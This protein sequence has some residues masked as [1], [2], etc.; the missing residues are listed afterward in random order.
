ME[1]PPVAPTTGQPIGA[2]AMQL[3]RQRQLH[4][5]GRRRAAQV[6]TADQPIRNHLQV[7]QK[8]G[9]PRRS[10]TVRPAQKI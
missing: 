7:L 8:S 2:P 6:R 10:G 4:T 5:A 3:L 1:N 9:A